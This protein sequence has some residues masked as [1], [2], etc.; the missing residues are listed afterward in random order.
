M[1][2]HQPTQLMVVLLLGLVAGGCS[3]VTSTER[4]GVPATD[5]AIKELNG[6]WLGNNEIIVYVQPLTEG[7]LR[8][9]GV[10][11]DGE[12]FKLQEMTAFLAT[13]QG[14]A[15]INLV[16]PEAPAGREEFMFLRMASIDGRRMLV[17][18]PPNADTFEKAVSDE[19]I[20]GAVK[21]E[22][23]SKTVQ[24]RPGKGE[25]DAFIEPDKAGEQFDLDMPLVLRRIAPPE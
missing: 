1:K 11:W 15:Y 20:P 2:H 21:N 14:V 19:Q 13:D 12:R 22:Q 5:E 17:L 6:V 24:L 16:N 4:L 9:A 10:E 23:F 8:I 3:T 25:L 18:Y 7:E